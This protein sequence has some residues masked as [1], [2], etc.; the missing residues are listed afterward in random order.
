MAALDYYS[1][2]GVDRKATEA[3]IKKAHKKMALKWHPD[4]NL[5]NS[6]E[7]TKKYQ[8]IVEAFEC[9][10][11]AEKRKQYDHDHQCD[12]VVVPR[13]DHVVVPRYDHVV[14]P[15]CLKFFIAAGLSIPVNVG[16]IAVHF[17]VMG[18]VLEP[19]VVEASPIWLQIEVAATCCCVFSILWM[20]CILTIRGC[21]RKN[22]CGCCLAV[23]LVGLSTMLAFLFLWISSGFATFGDMYI[24]DT[25]ASNDTSINP[26]NF[27]VYCKA[28]WM[29]EGLP[30][31]SL[32]CRG[33]A[34]FKTKSRNGHG[35]QTWH[36]G[37]VYQGAWRG[38]NMNG[39]GT[40]TWADGRVYQG[41]WVDGKRSGNG[42]QR[43]PDGRVYEG[44]WSNDK[45]HGQG[46]LTFPNGD[47]HQGEFVDASYHEDR[48]HELR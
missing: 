46:K 12:H 11:D 28:D 19:G 22:P 47:I 10:S 8:E 26:N 25:I 13:Y 44:Q 23:V 39:Q 31:I 29:F 42:T 33:S 1:V 38:N 7:A 4:K 35:N 41:D 20:M 43:W 14:V 37:D 34:M 36:N 6:E 24:G 18:I 2:L 16:L 17:F 30:P 40:Y 48:Q 21:I 32:T 15:R 9:L 3:E 45:Q 5:H 27:S